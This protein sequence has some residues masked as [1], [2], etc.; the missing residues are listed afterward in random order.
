MAWEEL[1]TPSG[2]SVTLN[3]VDLFDYLLY[4]FI[5]ILNEK[6]WYLVESEARAVLNFSNQVKP[7]IGNATDNTWLLKLER[8]FFDKCPDFA[9]NNF[10]SW[11]RPASYC[12]TGWKLFGKQRLGSFV[13][14]AVNPRLCPFRLPFV[15][16]L[17]HPIYLRLNNVLSQ[18]FYLLELYVY[19]LANCL[20]A[21]SSV[22]G[23]TI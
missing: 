16:L 9:R 15:S 8:V 7:L 5:I 22:S 4:I 19:A 23:C 20:P 3:F 2:N 14:P 12:T 11:Q 18:L 13:A 17:Y 10:L 1:K 6:K 21:S